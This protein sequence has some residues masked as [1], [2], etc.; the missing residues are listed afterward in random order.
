MPL[1]KR[2]GMDSKTRRKPG[3]LPASEDVLAFGSKVGYGWLFASRAFR[4]GGVRVIGCSLPK[5]QAVF[6]W[7]SSFW[8]PRAERVPGSYK[9]VMQHASPRSPCFAACIS[10]SLPALGRGGERLCR[11]LGP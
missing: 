7:A 3:D 11:L 4:A 8:R 1:R 6:S 9:E 2:E 10:G 5:R